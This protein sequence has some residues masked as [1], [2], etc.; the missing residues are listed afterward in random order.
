M[1]ALFTALLALARRV[2]A[3]GGAAAGAP[4][5]ATTPPPSA[6]PVNSGGADPS[7][8]AV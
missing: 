5:A 7:A 2:T 3:P 1:G 6:D 8:R 4:A